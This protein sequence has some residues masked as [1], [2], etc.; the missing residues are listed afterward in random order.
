M[1]V[2]T[3]TCAVRLGWAALCDCSAL[4][5]SSHCGCFPPSPGMQEKHAI[6]FSSHGSFFLLK[7]ADFKF[8]WFCQSLSCSLWQ[9]RGQTCGLLSGWKKC[10]LCKLLSNFSSPFFTTSSRSVTVIQGVTGMGTFTSSNI[11]HIFSL[12]A[13]QQNLNWTEYNWDAALLGFSVG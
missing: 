5:I 3:W 2:P 12:Q 11:Q 9:A 10:A 4:C 1:S 7:M 13:V 8:L 6:N